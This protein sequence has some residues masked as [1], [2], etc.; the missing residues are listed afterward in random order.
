M[1]YELW[2]EERGAGVSGDGVS[3]LRRESLTAKEDKVAKG[4][5]GVGI[6]N[7]GFWMEESAS[8]GEF[9]RQER[10]DRQGRIEL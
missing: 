9:N 8:V 10:Q 6:R 4:E 1:D 2:M 5:R 3:G 7:Y